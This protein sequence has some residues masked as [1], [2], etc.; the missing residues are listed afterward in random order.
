MNTRKMYPKKPPCTQY[1]GT[2]ILYTR[3][4]I[5]RKNYIREILY[6]HPANMKCAETGNLVALL[7]T[8]GVK[9]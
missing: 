1:K 7:L 8:T 5:Y 2:Q 6:M 4:I 9:C 3:N